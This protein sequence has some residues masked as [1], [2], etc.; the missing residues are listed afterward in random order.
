VAG[1]LKPGFLELWLISPAR[2]SA[3]VNMPNY[4]E[5]L[6][7][8]LRG[9]VMQ[10]LLADVYLKRPA[11]AIGKKWRQLQAKH[12]GA[13][14]LLRSPI[15]QVKLL[16]EWLLAKSFKTPTKTAHRKEGVTP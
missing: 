5:Y 16:A 12:P 9:K 3:G 14:A 4:Y 2:L 6:P 10:N 13:T 7:H 11:S 15:E 8:P 1:R